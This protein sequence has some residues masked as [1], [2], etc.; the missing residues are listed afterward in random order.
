MASVALYRRWRP[1]LFAEVLGQEHVCLTL[2]SAI[3]EGRV[4]HAYLFSGPR[5]TGKTSTARILAKALNCER[6]PAPEPC[7]ECDT[8]RAVS[9]GSSLDVIEIDAATHGGVDDVRELRENA[10]LAPAAARRKIYIVDEAHMI[11][12]AGWNAFLKTVEEP[13]PHVAFVFATTEPHKV[14][15]T[16]TS[17]CQRFDFRRVSS[18]VIAAHLAK[19]C[20]DEGVEADEAALHLIA[21]QAEGGVRDALSVLDQLATSGA[22]TPQATAA[23]VGSATDDVLFEFCDA[24]VGR[25]TGAAV[26]VISRMVEQ[27]RDLR[28]FVRQVLDHLRALFLVREAMGDDLVD[29]TEEVRAQLRA[30]ADRLAPAQAVHLIRLFLDAQ[31][32]MRQ[33]AAPRLAV[34]LAAVRATVPEADDSAQAA[35]ARVERLER[36]LDM[37]AAPAAAGGAAPAEPDAAPAAPETSTAAPEAARKG[38]RG[39]R[40]KTAEPEAAEPEAAEPE[41]A[42]GPHPAAGDLVDLEKIR[43][44]WS[45]VL[46][47]VRKRSRVTHTHLLD[48]RPSTYRDG[49]LTLAGSQSFHAQE[50]SQP[51]HAA[52][53]AEAIRQVL[54]VT[55]RIAATV[56]EPQPDTEAPDAGAETFDPLA[57]LREGL[58]AE[59]ID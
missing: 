47:R 9:E 50:I 10:L 12:A 21:R 20:L 42:P 36:L 30:Q 44:A 19:V 59:E 40:A 5:G 51:R 16:I 38:A 28:L 57:A 43:R 55:P 22:V 14:L 6:G 45:A 35:L 15:P 32:D 7:N 39:K 53:L 46:D 29:A 49:T 52:I 33:Q 31:A 56:T 2:Q 37:G 13:P 48:L 54:G 8:C 41:A 1:Q 25:D 23:L 3:R 26:S 17:R 18:A 24:L 27:G 4:A 11:T 58:G 34:E